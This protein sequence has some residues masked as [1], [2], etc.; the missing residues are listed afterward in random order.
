MAHEIRES[1]SFGE[2]R[3]HGKRA[4]HGLGIEIDEGTAVEGFK[5]IGL[6]WETELVPIH[7]EVQVPVADATTVEVSK[8]Q[9]KLLKKKITEKRAHVRLDTGAFLGIVGEDFKVMENQRLAEF[10]DALVEGSGPKGERATLE[11]AGSLYG[12][13][14]IFACVKLPKEIG[15]G[16]GGADVQEMYMLI[17][18]GHGGFASFSIYPTAVRVVCANTL[19]YS[20]KDLASGISFRHTGDWD[21][22]LAAAKVAVGMAIVEAEEFEKQAKALVRTNLSEKK[23]EEYLVRTYLDLFHG[24][25]EPD[26]IDMDAEEVEKLRV[27]REKILGQWT[28]KFH[29]EKQSLPGIRDSAWAAFNAVSE[30]E[31]HGRGRFKTVSESDS[32]I[33]SN[34]YGVSS[35]EKRTAFKNALSLV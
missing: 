2:V 30:W 23:F 13:R 16:K 21:A 11:T 34:V 9:F 19:R 22:K 26:V 8:R 4:W 33:H 28:E 5:R 10:A 20:E 32:R 24:G 29:N 25:K 17:G 12:G 1:D 14:R 3:V 6:G 35:R 27:K 31:D 7:Y 18:N 15:L